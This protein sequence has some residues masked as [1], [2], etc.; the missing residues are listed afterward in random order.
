MSP[1]WRRF[2][3]FFTNAEIRCEDQES[4]RD[5]F[6]TY[7]KLIYATAIKAGLNDAEAQDVVQDTVIAVAKKIEDFKYDPALDSFK[8]WLLYLTRKRIALPTENGS[9][10]AADQRAIQKC[11]RS[12]L[13]LSAS[14][15]RPGWT[16]RQSG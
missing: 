10:T 13:N 6:N 8:G 15:T 1:L 11:W 12:R 16:S 3:S 5:F 2:T 9:A 4:W 7:W 14:P